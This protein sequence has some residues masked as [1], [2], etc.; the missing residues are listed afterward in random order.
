MNF[1]GDRKIMGKIPLLTF[2]EKAGG[3]AGKGGKTASAT[4]LLNKENIC[5][6]IATVE[7]KPGTSFQ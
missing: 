5:V 7:K 1:Q 4:E 6:I 2:F 3:A